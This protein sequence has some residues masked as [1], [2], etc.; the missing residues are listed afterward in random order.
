[1]ELGDFNPKSL[2]SSL[3][4]EQFTAYFGVPLEAKGKLNGVLELY[5]RSPLEPN[6][7][8]LAFLDTLARQTAIAID[9][10]SLFNELQGSNLELR[11]AYDTTL[12]GW[13]NALELRDKETEGHSKRVTDLTLRLA[14]AMGITGDDLVQIRRGTALHDIGKMGI[15]DSILFK[16]GPLTED[17]WEIMRLHP[18][19]AYNLLSSIPF[20]RP[21]LD[22]PY[23]HHEKW[24][25]SGYPRGLQ[26]E[27]IPL[28]AR[29]F[30]IID[31]WD[32]LIN[33]R[34]YRKAW[35]EADALAYVKEQAGAHFDPQVVEAFLRLLSAH[36]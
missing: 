22:I 19:M 3:H 26:G 25:G 35:R 23:C 34:P 17:E 28:Q 5:H 32:A 2:I 24:D 36:C 10:A 12:D 15:S 6:P 20:L 30:A 13:A 21:A 4:E 9:N 14:S 27:Q 16:P 31:V 8:W 33:D 18:T 1:L 29:I 11:M 7:E